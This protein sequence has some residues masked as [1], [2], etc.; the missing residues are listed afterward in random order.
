MGKSEWDD[1]SMVVRDTIDNTV[2]KSVAS[3]LQVQM[4]HYNQTGYRAGQNYKFTTI[5]QLLDGNY[6]TGSAAW[7]LE[8]CWLPS[9]E[10]GELDYSSSEMQTITM[11]IRY[12]N[13]ILE[14]MDGANS[15]MTNPATDPLGTFLA[16]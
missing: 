13:A 4:D 9:V 11:G 10:Y 12:D 6:D 5:I 1:I 16:S 7:T 3:Q 14:S 8:G 15:I 2:T